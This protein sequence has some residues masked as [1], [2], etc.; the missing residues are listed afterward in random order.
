MLLRDRMPC[1]PSEQAEI[2][3][4]CLEFNDLDSL[5]Q[6]RKIQESSSDESEESDE[7]APKAAEEAKYQNSLLDFHFDCLRER[8]NLSSDDISRHKVNN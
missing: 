8:T 7:L 5:A 4:S 2:V 3:R 6:K 1:M